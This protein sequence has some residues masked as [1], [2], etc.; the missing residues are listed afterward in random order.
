V[1]TGRR[2][3]HPLL[4]LALAAALA[5]T[6]ASALAGPA[7][8]GLLGIADG[9]VLY[10]IN[11]GTGAASNPRTVGNKVYAIAYSPSGVLYGVSPGFPTDVPAGGALF[12]INVNN[13]FAT[14]VATLN[15]FVVVEGDIAFDPTSGILYAVDG[16]GQLFKINTTTGAGT[17]VGTITGNVDLSAM[18]FDATGNLYIVDS[19]GPTLLKV[20]KT[21][22]TILASLPM[23]AINQE[24]GGLA[25]DANNG[26]LY[27]SAGTVSKFYTVSTFSGAAVFVGPTPVTGGIWG[28]AFIPEPTPTSSSSWGRIK[29]L[30]R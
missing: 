5:T 11:T 15:T 30:Y 22:A 29:T 20:D 18:A 2:F 9:N 3:A 21:N 24:I 4:A 10:D 7:R 25:F 12:T 8:A 16:G 13:G 28:L 23:G 27:H 17:S 1:S 19:F 26:T 6:L 14:F